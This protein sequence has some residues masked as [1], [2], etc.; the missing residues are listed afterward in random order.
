MTHHPDEEIENLLDDLD[1][2]LGRLIE[3]SRT[4]SKNTITQLIAGNKAAAPIAKEIL[5]LV[6][7]S[8]SLAREEERKRCLQI[9]NEVYESGQHRMT[10]VLSEAQEI[11]DRISAL[12]PKTEELHPLPDPFKEG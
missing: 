4:G 11:A 9:V 3:A 8:L 12:P 5:T 10:Q 7:S 1:D 6:S 2:A